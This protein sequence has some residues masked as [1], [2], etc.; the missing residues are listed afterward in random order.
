MELVA[1]TTLDDEYSGGSS[2][3]HA[4]AVIVP[5]RSLILAAA[6]EQEKN[7]WLDSIFDVVDGMRIRQQGSS[8][9]GKSTLKIHRASLMAPSDSLSG[10]DLFGLHPVTEDDFMEEADVQVQVAVL[11]ARLVVMFIYLFLGQAI[12]S[13]QP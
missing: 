1:D 6:D 12:I 5:G 9:R 3:P 7:M 2:H 13:F 11:R 10:D 8:R 4:F